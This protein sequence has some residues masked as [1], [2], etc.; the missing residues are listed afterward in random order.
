M[1][2]LIDQFSHIQLLL[3]LQFRVN[4][5]RNCPLW[6]GSC[7]SANE[8][9]HGKTAW[10]KKNLANYLQYCGRL[11]SLIQ[12]AHNSSTTKEYIDFTN[13]IQQ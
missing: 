1:R 10:D 11:S 4:K 12:T 2:L 3:S 13:F 7:G 9:I 6:G 8:T 5:L